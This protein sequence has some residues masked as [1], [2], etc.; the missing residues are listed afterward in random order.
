MKKLTL[1][2]LLAITV[3]GFSQ[4]WESLLPQSKKENGT[5]TL[6]DYQKAFNT[7]WAPYHVDREGYYMKDGE[8]IKAA[9][10]KQ[11]KRWEFNMQ[12]RVDKKTGAFPKTS[13]YSERKKYLQKF[14]DANKSTAGNWVSLGMD[15]FDPGQDNGAGIGQMGCIAFHPT[16]VN[17]FWV[18]AANGGIWK[19]SDGGNSWQVL[20]DDLGVLG[21]AD[22]AVPSDYEVSHTIYIAT[23]SRD[24]FGY[25][26]LGVLKSTDGGQTWDQTTLSFLPEEG[27]YVFRIVINPDN[28]QIIY[29]ATSKG[30]FKT[31][32]GGNLWFLTIP[33]QMI[34]LEFH[35][36]NPNIIYGGDLSNGK[37]YRTTN[38]ASTWDVSL[39]SGG[40]RVEIAVSEDS[41]NSVYAIISDEGK[42][43]KGIYK[44]DNSGGSFWK[45]FNGQVPGNNLLGYKCDATDTLHGQGNFDICIAINPLDISEIVVGGILTWKSTDGGSNWYIIND[46]YNSND[47]CLTG[48]D[49]VHVDQHWLEYQPVSNRLFEVNDGGVFKSTDNGF[50]WVNLS[51]GLEVAQVEQISVSQTNPDMVIGGIYHNGSKRL[52]AGFWQNV[53]GGDGMNCLIDYTNENIQ[54]AS[55]QYGRISKTLNNWVNSHGIDTI[56]GKGAWLTPYT[57][58]PVNPDIFYVGT[59]QLFKSTDG[60]DHCT[61]IFDAG[62]DHYFKAIAVAP[63]NTDV[64]YISTDSL[65]WK[66]TNGGATSQNITNNLPLL[67]CN[68]TSITVKETNEDVIW[69]S[70]SGYDSHGVYKSTDGGQNWANISYGLPNVPIFSVV[71]N[72]LVTYAEEL[73]AGTTLGVFIKVKESTAWVPFYNQ[74]PSGPVR[75]VEIYYDGNNSKIVAA[76]WGR[77]VWQSDLYSYEP[78][79]SISWTGFQSTDWFD[80]DNWQYGVVPG[81]TNNVTIPNV[82][83]KPV[84]AGGTAYCNSLT[85]ESGTSLEII[86]NLN[87]SGSFTNYG[88]LVMSGSNADIDVT[89]NVSFEDGSTADIQTSGASINLEGSWLFNELANVQLNNG[90]VVFDG[91]YSKYVR[92]YSSNCWFNNITI[93]KDPNKYVYFSSSSTNDLIIKGDL[94]IGANCY[95]RHY[96]G[97]N[98]IIEGSLY[99]YGGILAYNGAID[100]AGS[101]TSIHSNGNS[102]FNN[103]IVSSGTNSIYDDLEVRGDLIFNGGTLNANG[104]D[105][106]IDGN[107]VNNIGDAA[108]IGNTGKVYF[109]G[110]NGQSITG[111]VNFNDFVNN[112]SSGY[113]E[114]VDEVLCNKYYWQNGGIRVD[115]DDSSSFIAL[116]LKQDGIYGDYILDKGHIELHNIEHVHLNGNLIINGGTFEVHGGSANSDWPGFVDASLTMTNG[117]LDFKDMGINVKNS[118]Q[119]LTLN[120][121]GGEIRTIGS[122]YDYRA[123]FHP[124]GGELTLYGQY[125]AYIDCVPGS[126]FYNLKVN[127]E[128][129][130]GNDKSPK[131]TMV[132]LL[133]DTEITHSCTIEEGDLDINGH[134]LSISDVFSVNDGGKLIMT[135]TSDTLK[136]DYMF[137]NSGSMSDITNGNIILQRDWVFN[138]GTLAEL[139]DYNKLRFKG[140]Y[141]QTIKVY[142]EDASFSVLVIE[143]T[144]GNVY[145]DADYI[146]DI[147]IRN[148]LTVNSQALYLNGDNVEVEGTTYIETGGALYVDNGTYFESGHCTILGDLEVSNSDVFVN[149]TLHHYPTGTLTIEDT[150]SFIVDGPFNGSLYDFEGL[151]DL[152]SGFFQLT[153]NGMELN[154]TSNINFNGGNLKLGANLNVT[155]SGIFNPTQGYVEFIGLSNNWVNL[156]P[157]N[158]FNGFI[159]NKPN[160]FQLELFSDLDINYD[161]HVQSG[162]LLSGGYDVEALNITIDSLGILNSGGSNIDLHGNWANYHGYDG[163]IEDG[164]NVK[165]IDFYYQSSILTEDQFNLLSIQKFDPDGSVALADGIGIRA[166]QLEVN[167]GKFITGNNTS[168]LV[169][170]DVVISPNASLIMPDASPSSLMSV[171]GEFSTDNNSL[172]EIGSGNDLSVSQF[173]HDGVLNIDG[174]SFDCNSSFY[175][176]NSS[177]TNL[178]NGSINFTNT[179]PSWMRL[180][181]DFN[182][183]GGTVDAHVNSIEIQQNFNSNITGGIFTT[184]GSFKAMYDNTFVQDGGSLV[185]T[186]DADS[187]LYLA[188]GCY[189]NDFVF[190]RT[191]GS[192]TLLTDLYVSNDFTLNSGFLDRS[193]GELFIGR[194]WANYA[195]PSAIN[196]SFGSVIF[197]SDKPASILTD[198]TFN[199]LIIDKSFADGNYLEVAA[200]KNIQVNKHFVAEDGM[201]K[202]NDN[203]ELGVNVIFQLQDGAGIYVSPAAST[204]IRI[205]RDWDN[206]NTDNNAN[207]GFWAGHSTVIFNG[208]SNQVINS[209]ATYEHFYKLMVQKPSGNITS[210]TDLIVQDEL[211]VDEGTWDSGPTVVQYTLFNNLSI[212]TNGLWL[213]ETNEIWFLGSSERAITDNSLSGSQFGTINVNLSSITDTVYVNSDLKLNEFTL[214]KGIV[215]ISGNELTCHDN[216]T[217]NSNANL[218]FYDGSVVKMGDNG[219]VSVSGGSLA[220]NGTETENILFTKESTGHYGFEVK[221]GGTVEAAFSR[222]EFLDLDGLHILSTGSIGGTAPLQNCTFSDGEINGIL[223]TIE[224]DQ[225]L[226]FENVSFPDNTWGGL[227]N[228]SKPNNNGH[229][230]FIDALGG[231][232]GEGF[233]SDPFDLVDWEESNFQLD[234]KAFLEGPFNGT[235]MNTTL[236]TNGLIPLDQPY[237]TSPWNYAG[238]ENVISIPSGVVD[239]VLIE[240]RDAVDAASA[241]PATI[242]E[243]QAAFLLDNGKIVDIHS[244][245]ECS[246]ATSIS[247]N[248]FVVVHHR[249]YLSVMSANAL[250]K[251]AG[252]YSYD[253]TT[254]VSQAYGDS[255]N[256]LGSGIY[257]FIG[258]DVNADGNI[259]LS[260]KTIWLNQAGTKGYISP[261]INMDGQSNNEDKNEFWLPNRGKW[262]YVPE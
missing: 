259:D 27:E 68:I 203:C 88:E 89:G 107:W 251:M 45:K 1:I 187:T 224:N 76:T 174:G 133:K 78:N 159:L 205:N 50:N 178:Y 254:D 110:D 94:F 22:I 66:I 95:F 221:S 202:L 223:L 165:F 103:L 119:S 231:F 81:S 19:T 75:E 24:N 189:I 162:E 148:H 121:S 117:V 194:N 242:V 64:I 5:L 49:K 201:L 101:G 149:Q 70:L 98:T 111:N 192:L 186:G 156:A 213:D 62:D 134:T 240:L 185:F 122:F 258:G 100:F 69:V 93:S 32:D 104:S 30:V 97:L 139:R 141:D 135:N 127:K 21:V 180:N 136:T 248:L 92:N 181:G 77:G 168:F 154:A 29:A 234:L 204:I 212:N 167:S 152:N 90:T 140:G 120:I 257:G 239:W 40:R 226:E 11:F 233:E 158:S 137:W 17:T 232:S 14:P 87:V 26:S 36:T 261:D 63:S 235:G 125:N 256:N 31:S 115:S 166:N 160:Y 151:I 179:S 52:T 241:I 28:D 54:Y 91:L 236:N 56:I 130:K 216:I 230:T 82:S 61:M 86:D 99:N 227:Y 34:D 220:L 218:S 191:G 48:Y 39:E 247:N 126:S 3:T 47:E 249:N 209:N 253:F 200:N 42:G 58:D 84:I 237:N 8:K 79:A 41:P 12:Y 176:G 210:N 25:G 4:A 222:F 190:N 255:Q 228:V 43:M 182:M 215:S 238:T 244:N 23:G 38:G 208:T 7:Y 15:H 108:F 145:T 106:V 198:E 146:N 214:M 243:R 147:Y 170:N 252:V 143:K 246:F 217:I 188:D 225:V 260:D 229:L 10:W 44:S 199:A 250:V 65:L 59:K 206:Q 161:L 172:L 183:S 144:G 83:L 105:I 129:V 55:S 197:N 131:S 219:T 114:I 128:S 150:S 132:A 71:Q 6:H 109:E 113:L 112:I 177:V 207:K 164:S 262:S 118:A 163:F 80:G 18:G 184:Q 123:D 51:N 116:D 153:N 173:I 67:N 142:E 155:N 169:Y 60:G 171:G 46:G 196:L 245:V 74:L 73:Y 124:T 20:N 35:P 193:S 175:L 53:L 2:I 72:K 9:G 16:N 37:I 85:I 211:I 157:G 13:D 138:N 102:Y 96:S 57:L 195:G 33:W